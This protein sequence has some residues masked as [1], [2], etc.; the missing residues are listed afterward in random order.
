MKKRKTKTGRS[1]MSS[2]I[3]E[4]GHTNNKEKPLVLKRDNWTLKEIEAYID[5]LEY[6]KKRIPIDAPKPVKTKVKRRIRTRIRIRKSSP[7]LE[8]AHKKKR[9]KH[10]AK[11]KPVSTPVKIVTYGAIAVFGLLLLFYVILPTMQGSMHFLI[12]LSGSMGPDINP[13]DIVVST[14][15]NPE[16]IKMNDVITFTT[17]D[18]PKNCVTHRVINI[19]NEQGSINFQ[20]KGDANEEPDLNIVQSSDVVGKVAFVIPYLGYV[21]H[22]AKSFLGFITLIIIPGCLIIVSEVFSIVKAKKKGSK[23]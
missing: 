2:S 23:G 17:A 20:T 11:K 15:I 22:F 6:G 5:N 3:N 19:T 9:Q 1:H 14:Y 16:E 12:V 8:S 7:S 10:I 13:G 18:D 4:P 21:P